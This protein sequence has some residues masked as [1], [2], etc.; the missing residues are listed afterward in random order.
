MPTYRSAF[1]EESG[2]ALSAT[3]RVP[4]RQITY[5][6]NNTFLFFYNSTGLLGRGKRTSAPSALRRRQAKQAL[7]N[8]FGRAGRPGRLVYTL[9]N[10]SR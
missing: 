4:R 2:Q 9:G 6:V 10:N 8:F 5:C 3:P 7:H 1:E